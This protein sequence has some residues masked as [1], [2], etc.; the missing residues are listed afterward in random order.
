MA[1]IPVPTLSTHG[2]VTSPPEKADFLISHF[3]E[4]DKAQTYLYGSNITNLQWLIERY[5]H[6]IPSLCQQIRLALETY[7]GRYYQA[8]TV[9][10]LNDASAENKTSKVML[11][12]YC[13]VVEEGVTYSIGK[14]LTISDSKFEKITDLNNNEKL[15]P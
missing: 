5:G 11:R 10:V 9:E 13:S 7:L 6:E 14:L 4:S 1:A 2:W 12:L 15:T 3:Y 8:A